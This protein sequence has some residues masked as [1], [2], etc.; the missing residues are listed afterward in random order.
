MS[1]PS[2]S[3]LHDRTRAQLARLDERTRIAWSEYLAMTRASAPQAYADTEAF[4]WRR[5]RRSLAELTATDGASTSS[6]IDSTQSPAAS[7]APRDET[8]RT[9]DRGRRELEP[10]RACG[11]SSAAPAA[12]SAATRP[13]SRTAIA[14][15]A[16]PSAELPSFF[17]R[18]VEL[19]DGSVVAVT[20][21]A[22]LDP[23]HRR[24]GARGGPQREDGRSSR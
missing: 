20:L 9:L 10:G 1:K 6:S 16:L 8:S 5:L 22:G 23:R 11:Q 24:A 15:C 3:D 7:A 21:L 14:S 4:A 18:R 17:C 12:T 2:S 19:A 13:G